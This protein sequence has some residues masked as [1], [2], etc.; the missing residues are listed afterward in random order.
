[1]TEHTSGSGR[2]SFQELLDIKVGAKVTYAIT[3]TVRRDLVGAVATEIVVAPHVSRTDSNLSDNVL[4]PMLEAL[5]LLDGD[6]NADAH[7]NFADFVIISSNYGNAV[8]SRR[9]GD[10]DGNGRVDFADFVAVSINYLRR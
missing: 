9:E 10:L 6:V 1:M 8:T 4:T 5:P 2:G 7:V 3:G